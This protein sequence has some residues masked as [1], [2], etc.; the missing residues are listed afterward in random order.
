MFGFAKANADVDCETS[1]T[2]RDFSAEMDA[3][4]LKG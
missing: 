4:I 2:Q 3:E 1:G